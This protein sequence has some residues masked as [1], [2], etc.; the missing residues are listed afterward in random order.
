[1]N[2][3]R[4]VNS[5]VG[6]LSFEMRKLLSIGAIILTATLS[7]YAASSETGEWSQTVDGIQGRLSISED[8]SFHGTRMF[9]IYLE[10][11]N[12]S[13][14]ADP[15]ELYFDWTHSFHC[16][17]LDKDEKAV[18]TASLPTSIL[19]PR[20]FWLSLPYDGVVRFRVSVCGFMVPANSGALIPML[21]GEWLVKSGDGND[22]WF[23]ATLVVNPPKVEVTRRVWK[24]TLKLPRVKVPA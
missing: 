13:P 11:R 17:L 1:M 3:R 22:Y 16:R 10:L 23:D 20:P 15:F 9:A 5:N 2:S 18:P 6:C 4:R 12:V 21:C 7:A 19:I 14:V 8:Q 24:G